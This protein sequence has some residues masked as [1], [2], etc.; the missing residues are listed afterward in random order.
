MSAVH[1]LLARIPVNLPFESLLVSCQQLYER[2]PPYTVEKEA[3][4]F[5]ARQ[6]EERERERA[7]KAVPVK[8]YRHVLA[9]IVIYS[10][11]VL[12]G[13]VVWRVMMQG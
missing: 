1:G 3:V 10:A 7:V 5:L 9:R 4:L 2:F 11:P 6:K 13:V 8:T 12:L